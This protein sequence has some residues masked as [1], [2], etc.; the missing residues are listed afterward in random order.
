[1][2]DHIGNL[3]VHGHKAWLAEHRFMQGPPNGLGDLTS[4]VML[5]NWLGKGMAGPE[6]VLARTTASI[7]EVMA[8]A[9][10]AGADELMLECAA[11][12]LLRPRTKIE[13]R[14]LQVTKS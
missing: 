12:S 9:A 5:A 13:A 2:R 10:K 14:S 8:I 4:A 11:E 1:M 7:Y 3:M 6:I